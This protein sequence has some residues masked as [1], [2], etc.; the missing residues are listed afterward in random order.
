MRAAGRRGQAGRAGRECAVR[1]GCAV[2]ARAPPRGGESAS[3]KRR[4][5]SS[6]GLA[7]AAA[8]LWLCG[9]CELVQLGLGDVRLISHSGTILEVAAS[10]GRLRAYPASP[11]TA[12]TLPPALLHS[13]TLLPGT[14]RQPSHRVH[15]YT[16]AC[17][18]LRKRRR[19]DDAGR[20]LLLEARQTAARAERGQAW[21]RS[22]GTR[23]CGTQQF[24]LGLAAYPEAGHRRTSGATGRA[25]RRV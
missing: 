10:K 16:N 11:L 4:A 6:T 17:N 13:S 22:A 20:S 14:A 3:V 24:P 7:P 1:F 23:N 5:P 12:F 9:C 15:R 18:P 25:P 21:I 19:T 2:S 8:R